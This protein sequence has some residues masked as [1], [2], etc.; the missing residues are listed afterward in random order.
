[1]TL[2]YLCEANDK[3]Y[4]NY[5]CEKCQKIKRMIHLHSLER[6]SEILDIVLLRTREEENQKIK[7]AIDEEKTKCDNTQRKLRDR[8]KNNKSV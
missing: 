2:C 4:F 6:V 3:S 1:M 5:Y 8:E 7:T